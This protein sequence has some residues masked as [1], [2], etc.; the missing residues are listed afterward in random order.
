M[1]K[2]IILFI[3]LFLFTALSFTSCSESTGEVDPYENWD[4]RNQNFVDSI[5]KVAFSNS[6][7]EV[8]EWKIFYSYKLPPLP[9]GQRGDVNDY[10]YCKI[11]SVG[12]GATPLFTDTAYVS[13]KGMLINNYV[14]EKSYSGE[15]NNN[16]PSVAFVTGQLVT[17]F[18]TAL[19]NMKVGDIWR[20]YIP[21]DLAYGA[22]KYS[23]IPANS[24]LIFDIALRKVVPLKGKE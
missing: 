9:I 3:C 1:N 7:E 14:F 5:A 20:V 16:S 11:K 12:N 18:T 17:G 23:D 2:N 15:F 6:G 8:G 22:T 21:S 19:E 4:Q 24:T 13:Y 10:V